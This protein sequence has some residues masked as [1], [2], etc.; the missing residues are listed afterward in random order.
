MST[1]DALYPQWSAFSQSTLGLVPG[2]PDIGSDLWVTFLRTRY[3]VINALNAAYRGS[4]LK[5]E[6][7]P[8]PTDL[9]RQPQPLLDWYQFQGVLLVQAAAH[10]F[11]VFLPMP[12]ADAQDTQAHR[13]K[14]DLAQRVVDLEKPAHTTYK[15]KFYWAFFRVGDAR[16][17]TDSVLDH[18]S[19]APQLLRPVVLGDSYAGSGYIS[20]EQPCQPRQRQF[21]NTNF[22]N[23]RSC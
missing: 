23:Q 10:Q 12:V 16:L 19:R 22:S 13:A 6:T 9:P 1:G 15:I 11:T 8:F 20:H 14:L 18:G 5:F 21:L 17:G 7:V 3:G 2:Q 4:Y